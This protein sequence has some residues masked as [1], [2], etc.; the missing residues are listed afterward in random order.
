VSFTPKPYDGTALARHIANA[1]ARQMLVGPD[2]G[3]GRTPAFNRLPLTHTISGDPFEYD[4]TKA[5]G[6]AA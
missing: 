4:V 6:K 5:K 2:K 3:S 1:T